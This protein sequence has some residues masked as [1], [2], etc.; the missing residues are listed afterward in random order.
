VPPDIRRTDPEGIDAPVWLFTALGVHAYARYR[1][2][3]DPEVE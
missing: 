3:D 1:R 2:G